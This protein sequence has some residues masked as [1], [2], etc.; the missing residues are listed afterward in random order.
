[1][2]VTADQALAAAKARLAG[3]AIAFPLWWHGD[4]APILPDAPAA[5]AYLVFNNEGAGGRPVAF[6][7]GRGA[8]LYRSRALLEAF[9]FDPPTGADGMGPV[10][11]KAE[12]IAARLRSFRDASI[13][14]FGADVIPVGPGSSIAPPGLQS[15]VSNYLCAVVECAMSF[16]QIG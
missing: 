3:G 13:S 8:N 1:M 14:C 11:Q 6:G 10:M 2:S 7:G 15:E 16:D 4:P 12:T 5:F 9:V